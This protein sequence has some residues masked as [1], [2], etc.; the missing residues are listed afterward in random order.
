MDNICYTCGKEIRYIGFVVTDDMGEE[1][2]ECY[3]CHFNE[4]E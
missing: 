2:D 3:N 4:E 1:Q